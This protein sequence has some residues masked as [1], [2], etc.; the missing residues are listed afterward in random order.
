M[1]MAVIGLFGQHICNSIVHKIKTTLRNDELATMQRQTD[2]SSKLRYV[3]S[4]A[5]LEAV[6]DRLCERLQHFQSSHAGF[7]ISSKYAAHFKHVFVHGKGT[8]TAARMQFL[9]MAMP[10]ALRG[11][12]T[13]EIALI[14]RELA[15]ESAKLR[16]LVDPCTDMVMALNRFLDWFSMARR[17]SFPVADAPELQKRAR[18]MSIELQRVFPEKSGQVGDKPWG[19]PKMHAPVHTASE[20]LSCATTP[21]TD[22]NVFEAGHKPNVKSLQ[23]KTNRKDQFMSIS[24][25][26]DRD[27]NLVQLNQAV[28]RHNKLLAALSKGDDDDDGS[29]SNSSSGVDSEDDLTFDDKG[30][31]PCELAAKLPLW[32]MSFDMSALHKMPEALGAR[33]KGR[34]R[35]V[36]AAF[37]AGAAP[38]KEGR[39]MYSWAQ[40]CPELKFLPQQL[41][42]YAY[43]YLH[44]K[45]GLDYISQAQRD[46]Q[47]LD[48]VLQTYLVPDRDKCDIF[49]FGGLAIRCAH[50][51]GTVRV[52]A[53]PFASDA[54]HGRNPQVFASPCYVLLSTSLS[55]LETQDAVLA[56]PGRPDWNRSASSFDGSNESHREQMWVARVVLFFKCTFRGQGPQDEPIHCTLALVSRLREFTA[57]DARESPQSPHSPHIWLALI[58]VIVNRR[59]AKSEKRYAYS[60][61]VLSNSRPSSH[62]SCKHHHES[63]SGSVLSGRHVAISHHSSPVR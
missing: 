18:K 11:L 40:E 25:F 10:F 47:S 4:E 43:E 19:F 33:G 50:F 41:A 62:S 9:M 20:I 2:G 35:L 52:R 22:T 59:G 30:S 57:P 26:H 16:T 13:P 14:R 1:H 21:F 45:L 53:R 60:V 54:F 28:S 39:F 51:A 42:H 7:Q 17:L 6:Y 8:F 56:I 34:Q 36:L 46:T 48:H 29:S 61:R 63:L 55:L 49:T 23:H 5:A 12:L 24:K 32:D 38:P 44:E 15:G 58:T 31:R 27:T 3:I 37:K